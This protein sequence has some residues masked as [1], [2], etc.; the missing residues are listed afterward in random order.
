[1]A[2]NPITLRLDDDTEI[3]ADVEG[4]IDERTAA[5]LSS[6]DRLR[7][8]TDD[9]DVSGHAAS[10]VV[11]LWITGPDDVEGHALALRLPSAQAAADFRR[12][13]IAGGVLAVV[14]AGGVVASQ[15]IPSAQVT[16]DPTVDQVLID[17]RASERASLS[18]VSAA[19][20]V[21]IDHRASEKSLSSTTAAD[22]AAIAQRGSEKSLTST[23]AA[24][25][26]LIAQRGSEKSLTS[27]TAAD[28]ALIAHRAS[29]KE[30]LGSTTVDEAQ[31][32][33][34]GVERAN[35]AGAAAADEALIQHRASEKT[36]TS[37]TAAEEAVIQHR[38]SE[39]DSL[40][41]TD[42]AA[43]APHTSDWDQAHAS[44]GAA[45]GSATNQPLDRDA[46][47]ELPGV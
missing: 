43:V 24:D 27:T 14:V 17:H 38:A 6:G 39:R 3:T 2:E 18:S 8:R 11:S 46:D 25:E 26:A 15:T 1:M 7:L 47:K 21:V 33:P 30:S 45:G 4:P 23:T 36:L 41:V 29:E 44:G 10:D 13:L 31:F 32:Q 19:D 9:V 42:D 37:T 12:N 28:E 22:E 40:A 5:L 16:T 34:S 35:V 20:Q